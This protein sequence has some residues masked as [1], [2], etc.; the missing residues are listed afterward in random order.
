MARMDQHQ[1]TESVELVI[2]PRSKDLG[3]F[4]VRRVLP[5]PRRRHLGPFVFLDHMGPAVFGPGPALVVRPHPHINL[6][7]VTYLF[8]GEILHR[9]SLGYCQAISP[10][11]IN[12]M[13]AGRGIVHSEREH[14]ERVL[15]ERR[16]HGLQLWVALPKE[17]EEHEPEFTH[18]PADTLPEVESDGARLRVLAGTAFG[19]TSPVAT[20]SRLFYVDATLAAGADLKL[21]LDYEERGVYLLDGTLAVDGVS[22]Q[23]PTLLVLRPAAEVVLH[24][25]SRVHMSLLGGDALDGERHIYW[26]FV[27]S[28]PERIEEA[29]AAWRAGEFPKVPGDEIDFI[30]LPDD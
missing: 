16:L 4:S 14:P 10:G 21:E 27:S 29:K 7:T 30:P 9:D 2:E 18:Y 15:L 8:E 17:H 5:Y 3:G 28:R 22:Y 13:T 1:A 26:N 6:A 20:L 24:A 12:W 19:V 11:A 25:E 23:A